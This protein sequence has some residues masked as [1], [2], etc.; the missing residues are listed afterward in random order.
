MELNKEFTLNGKRLIWKTDFYDDSPVLKCLNMNGQRGTCGNIWN[1]V[2]KEEREELL[3]NK[4]KRNK[5]PCTSALTLQYVTRDELAEEIKWTIGAD[6]N[7]FYVTDHMRNPVRV[8]S[9]ETERDVD[10]L[11]LI[12]EIDEGNVLH[13]NVCGSLCDLSFSKVPNQDLYVIVTSEL[14]F[15]RD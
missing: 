11:S 6:L 14:V 12:K 10:Q 1:Y 8:Y 9:V 2:T 13:M 3:K 4:P 15:D 5:L 7:S